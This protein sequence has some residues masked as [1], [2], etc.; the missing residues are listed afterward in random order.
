MS[1]YNLK[2]ED[3]PAVAD[4]MAISLERDLTDFS[5][6]YKNM[7]ADYLAE[8]KAAS[9]AVKAIT[10]DVLS[11]AKQRQATKKAYSMAD[12]VKEG[13]ILL[14]DYADRA[15]LDSKVLGGA[16]KQFNHRNIEGG[17]KSVRGALPYFAEHADQMLAMPDGFLDQM[18]AGITELEELNTSQ[19]KVMN[20]RRLGTS[21]NKVVHD[22]LYGF[23]AEVA[24]A[25]KLIY[26]SGPKRDEYTLSKIVARVR[27][28][29]QAEEKPA[30]PASEE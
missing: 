17:I 19:S 28:A 27:A 23:I 5:A 2:H 9:A 3:Y 13:V 12:R 7:N 21:D 22:R 20:D 1:N 18:A 24:R 4:I 26:K 11:L 14:K 15:K 8:F 29:R 25:G 10:H 30:P 16:V 6:K